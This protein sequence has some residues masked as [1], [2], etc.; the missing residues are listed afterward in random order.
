MLFI[1]GHKDSDNLPA[2][3][4]QVKL[5]KLNIWKSSIYSIS[6]DKKRVLRQVTGKL[7]QPKNLVR[8]HINQAQK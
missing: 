7:K 6:T 4:R 5:H 1:K 8:P 3:Y 2:S